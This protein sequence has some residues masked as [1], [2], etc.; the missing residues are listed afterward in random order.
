MSNYRP[1]L[2]IRD[3]VVNSFFSSFLLYLLPEQ[4]NKDQHWDSLFLVNFFVKN[5]KF[6]ITV[7]GYVSDVN[8]YM[9]QLSVCHSGR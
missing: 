5:N 4:F 3:M 7:L 8:L 2:E 9:K 1:T 6:K